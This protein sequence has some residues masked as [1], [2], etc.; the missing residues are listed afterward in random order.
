MVTA[1][2]AYQCV[3]IPRPK[4]IITVRDC[5]KAG[6]CCDKHILDMVAQHQPDKE[7]KNSRPKAAIKS[8]C[9]VKNISLDPVEPSKIVRICS[10][11]DSK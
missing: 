2:Y 3:K 1:H 7:I 10:N 9:E 4:V 5:P 8:H 6:L 11:L